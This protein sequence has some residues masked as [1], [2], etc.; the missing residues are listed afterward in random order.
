MLSITEI[1]RTCSSLLNKTCISVL[2][3]LLHISPIQGTVWNNSSYET[4]Y[5]LKLT[6]V[7]VCLSVC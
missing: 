4:V 1:Y 2:L 7:S 5:Y 3:L 6:S